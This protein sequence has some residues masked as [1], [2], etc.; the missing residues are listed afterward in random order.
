M[1]AR[2]SL[3]A[4]IALGALA[5]ACA[6]EAEDERAEATPAAEMANEGE[7]AS[8]AAAAQ[9]E[10]AFG[11]VN[12][13]RLIAADEE[14]DQWLSAARTYDEQRFSPLDAVNTDNVDELGLAWYADMNT[15]RGQ[16]ATPV[17]VDGALY[18]TTAWSMVKAFDAATGAPLWDFDPEVP[19][20]YGVNA[21]CDVVNRGVAVWDGK[22]YVG[23]L[24]GELIALDAETGEVVW[25][26][27][28]IEDRSR[29]YTITGVP[30]IVDGLVMIGNGGAEYGVRG[31]V[32]A[33]D[34]ET[35]EQAWR[36]YTV[37]GNPADGFENE[38]MEMAADT[39]N[40]EWWFLGGGGT[41]W[42]GMAYDVDLDLL[43]IGVG[44]GSP[45]NQA[46]RSPGGG[47]NLFLSSI[48]ALRPDTGEYVWHYQTTPGETWDYTAT[49]PIMVADLEIDGE[50]RRVVMQAPKNGFFYVL[51]AET[52]ELISAETFAPIN[53]A[54]HVDMETGRPVEVEAA[55]YDKT[56]EAAVV[57]PAPLGAHNWHPMSFSPETGYVYLP[58]VQNNSA[59][60]PIPSAEF[61]VN[62]IGW[63]IGISFA[64][65]AAAYAAPGA[66]ARIN[67]GYLQ[68]WDP[69]TQSAAWTVE[70]EGG[71]TTGGTLATAGGLVFQ[72]N[73]HGYFLAFDAET[74]ETL[75]NTPTQTG[76]VAAPSTYSIDG[77]QYVAVLAG[78]R[79]FSP[80]AGDDANDIGQTNP[81]ST[82]NSRL[83]VFKLGASGALP[84]EMPSAETDVA[85]FTPP[86]STAS[87]EVIAAGAAVYAE[88]CGVCHGPDAVSGG[89]FP[90]LR[91]SQRL[92]DE[93]AWNAV[94]VGG[95]LA[96]N[97]MVSFEAVLDD[98]ESEAIMAYV[99]DRANA[100]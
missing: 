83:L 15:Q 91:Q 12:A 61:E 95:E 39:W 23:T 10:H 96:G 30:R 44:N 13:A 72:G 100:E 57:A 63:N 51:D 7:T 87:A 27:D 43:Y 85:D 98:G 45:W 36:W 33:Y 32:T 88:N 50:D 3:F 25:R 4:S 97:G 65:A 81:L 93:A 47:D 20:E 55:R 41:V 26:I 80:T 38:A 56:G 16:E 24:F 6:P 60:A 78:S 69:V 67:R 76:I 21:C 46:L 77:E 68:A 48:V 90:D 28:T 17:V 35:G 71:G 29:P 34:A 99:I 94:V 86:E 73:S 53:W 37:P 66:P 74:G 89:T 64:G 54:T 79:G 59:Y 8:P 42:D 62:P 5:V 58:T 14:P 40:G 70:P 82:N 49:Q 31:Y 52:G 22:V 92:F 1:L 75:W 84:R 19:R 9:P 11:Q 18:V 2:S